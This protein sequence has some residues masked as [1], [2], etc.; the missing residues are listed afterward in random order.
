LASFTR[1]FELVVTL[2]IEKTVDQRKNN[3]D[4]YCGETRSKTNQ[5]REQQLKVK[6]VM[7]IRSVITEIKRPTTDNEGNGGDQPLTEQ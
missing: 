4:E 3:E 6:S 2:Y 1:T 7:I 5:W